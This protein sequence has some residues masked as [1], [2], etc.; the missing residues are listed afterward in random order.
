[1]S[2]DNENKNVEASSQKAEAASTANPMKSVQ[3][4]PLPTKWRTL[5]NRE[6]RK[7]TIPNEQSGIS[8]IDYEVHL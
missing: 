1:M 7:M 6:R 5:V 4:M 2:K 8:K 3:T